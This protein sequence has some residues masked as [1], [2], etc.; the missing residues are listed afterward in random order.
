MDVASFLLLVLFGAFALPVI[1]GRDDDADDTSFIYDNDGDGAETGTDGADR[2]FGWAE[3]ESEGI[4]ATSPDDML[5]GGAGD[6]TLSGGIGNDTLLGGDGADRLD[7]GTGDD[8]FTGGAG[9]DQ[10]D[11][12]IDPGTERITDLEAGETVQIGGFA[13]APMIADDGTD[14]KIADSARCRD[15]A[16]CLKAFWRRN[17]PSQ[18]RIRMALMR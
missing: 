12:G 6:D 3:T 5:D 11:L 4:D 8:V 10:F 14:T 7:C 9:I 1:F 18:G 2:I 16:C 17:W 13:S 15:A